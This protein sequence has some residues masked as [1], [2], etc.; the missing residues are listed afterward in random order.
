M[1]DK[2]KKIKSW[3]VEATVAN[4]EAGRDTLERIE[5]VNPAMAAAVRK[6][7][8]RASRED[9]AAA[10]L[11]GTVIRRTAAAVLFRVAE[12]VPQNAGASGEAWWPTSQVTVTDDV[13]AGLAVLDAP[14]W[15][16]DKKMGR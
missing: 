9:R 5:G 16:A 15:L 4:I 11:Y 7:R 14:R 12:N 13:F 2:R 3:A 1:A 6:F 8:G 10:V